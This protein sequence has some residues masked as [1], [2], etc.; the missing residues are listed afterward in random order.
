MAETEHDAAMLPHMDDN[1]DASF[2]SIFGKEIK[3]ISVTPV[4]DNLPALST[5]EVLLGIISNL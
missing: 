3:P 2:D 5:D 4:L 1:M